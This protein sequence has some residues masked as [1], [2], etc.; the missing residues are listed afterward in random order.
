MLKT[1]NVGYMVI[2]KQ[3]FFTERAW[4]PGVGRLRIPLDLHSLC[5]RSAHIMVFS[6][7][8]YM[9]TLGKLKDRLD[10]VSCKVSLRVGSVNCGVQFA[11]VT[12]Y[13]Q[14]ILVV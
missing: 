10:G 5:A 8:F 12:R 14:Y 7:K 4:L 11:K 13:T 6:Q 9:N 3:C 1:N 2:L